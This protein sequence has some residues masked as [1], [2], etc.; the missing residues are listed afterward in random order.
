MKVITRTKNHA[1]I[2]ALNE[3]VQNLHHTL[4]PDIFKPFDKEA[5]VE[6]IR[7]V[8]ADDNNY[9][10]V[11]TDD[12]ETLGYIICCVKEAKEN[13]F[14]YTIRTLYIDQIGV[15]QKYRRNGAGD[16]LMQQAEQ[17]AKELSIARIELDHWSANSVAAAYFR[18]QGYTLCKERLCKVIQ[19]IAAV[20]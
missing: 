12:G 7:N 5:T 20:K 13:A 10:Y 16:M 8:L 9:A 3:E 11:V 1:L 2:A 17:L 14:H 4:H 19:A 6:F 18:R 15:L